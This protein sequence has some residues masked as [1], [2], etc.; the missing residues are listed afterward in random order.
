MLDK[1]AS[2]DPEPAS[3]DSEKTPGIRFRALARECGANTFELY[4]VRGQNHALI[5][6]FASDTR[7]QN[8]APQFTPLPKDLAKSAAAT[9]CIL[10]WGNKESA[11]SKALSDSEWAVRIHPG[12]V[13][14]GLAMPLAAWDGA[15]GLAVFKGDRFCNDAD[16]FIDI[17]ASCHALF[18]ELPET[19]PE[20][21]VSSQPAISRREMQCLKLTANGLTSEEIALELGLSVHTANRYL[22]NATQKLNA[23]NRIHAVANALREGLID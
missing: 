8:T 12:G 1:E 10:W 15:Q 13:Q 17:H 23:T 16:R 2:P 7:L 11:L 22:A 20:R 6:V 18:D 9:A 14:P 5:P 4:R 21:E 3:E 19:M